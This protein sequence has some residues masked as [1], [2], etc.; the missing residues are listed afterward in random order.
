MFAALGSVGFW[1]V[2]FVLSL[3]VTIRL[4]K[5]LPEEHVPAYNYIT[6]NGRDYLKKDVDA[7][8]FLTTFM[9]LCWP[10]IA[11]VLLVYWLFSNLVWPSVCK[12]MTVLDR[13]V[14]TVV[15]EKQEGHEAPEQQPEPLPERRSSPPPDPSNKSGYCCGWNN[16]RS[17]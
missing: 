5:M 15:F 1:V 11:C 8:I 16:N 17:N 14:P 7:Y 4:L 13:K 2:Y 3:F 6:Q 9:L 10:V 12:A